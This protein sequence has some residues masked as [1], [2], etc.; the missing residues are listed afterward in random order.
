M[1]WGLTGLEAVIIRRPYAR[2]YMNSSEHIISGYP[3]SGSLGGT[4]GFLNPAD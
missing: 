4:R 3:K 1:I 2:Y